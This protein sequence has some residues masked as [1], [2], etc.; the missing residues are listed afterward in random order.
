MQLA[1]GG[2]PSGPQGSGPRRRAQSWFFALAFAG[3]AAGSVAGVLVARHR[4]DDSAARE[5][6]EVA[7]RAVMSLET[8]LGRTAAGVAG[9]GVLAG[10]DGTLDADAF[11]A[12]A[13]GLVAA[14]DVPTYALVEPAAGAGGG[15][16]VIATVPEGAAGGERVGSIDDGRADAVETALDTGAGTAGPTLTGPVDLLGPAGRGVE[17]LQPVRTPA[18]DIAGLVVVGLPARDLARTV[19]EAVG[20][21]W[22]V[23]LVDGERP[24]FGPQFDRRTPT[25]TASPD[26]DR[27]WR[28]VVGAGLEPDLTVAWLVA[29]G[30][31]AAL[32]AFAALAISSGRHQKRLRVAN[33]LLRK[34]D[35]R[36]R[37]VQEVAGRLARALTAGEIVTALVDHL[38]TAVGAQSA[39]IVAR[40]E[41]G[42]LEV[43]GPGEPDDDADEA[44]R[45][46]LRGAHRTPLPP[47]GDGTTHVESA[48]ALGQPVWLR[49]PLDWRGDAV[50][51]A[52]A[53]GGSALALL[54]LSGD[55]VKGVI[56]VSYPRVRI[57]RDD[58]QDLL[59]TVGLLA[60]RALA[61]G[62]RYDA[63]HTAAVAFQRAAL[64][65]ELPVVDGLS[66]V[67][68]YRPATRQATVGG[69]WYD[70]VVLGD[71]RV[72]LVVGDV[73]G[74]GMVA[75]AAMGRI[76]SAFQAIARLSAGPGA[77]V[78]ALSSQIDTIPDSFCTTMVCVEVDV[79]AGTMTWCR[80]G[81]P[82]P[83]V[84]SAGTATL[85]DEPGLPPLGVAPDEPARVHTRVLGPGDRVV[86]YT[87]G[88]VERR[89]ESID[90]GL[91]RLGVVAETL[92]D[93]EPDEFSDALVEALVPGE[94]ADDIAIL[95]V[96]IDGVAPPTPDPPLAAPAHR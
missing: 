44:A 32:A 46:E 42:R 39:V 54:P 57:F 29:A 73:V 25:V 66:I 22:S 28:V 10:P 34:S 79:V 17:L 72:V 65:D 51:D 70:V 1:S 56:A 43:L 61:R 11:E 68:R 83:L 81:H 19:R 74:H 9:A 2:Q 21:G 38:P 48:M 88:V 20:P 33:D 12:F 40:D 50:T 6:E 18:G 60:G 41:V 86:L 63:E 80:A 55:D 94:Q 69:D 92:D 89:E 77:M 3:I 31:I 26:V 23:A 59:Q 27:P 4:A 78:A 90:E 52:L 35:D 15:L 7:R 5:V 30:G 58:E 13:T 71:R 67:G 96:R 8:R 53:A 87:D 64:P 82:P 75:A 84:L 14:D 16:T 91:R 36:T 85:L 95:V 47:H 45:A 49:S 62:R 24:L 76:R 37:A 93:L